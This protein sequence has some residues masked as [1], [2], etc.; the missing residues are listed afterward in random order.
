MKN[1]LLI[2][3]TGN[4]KGKTTAALGQ[5][6]RALG[7]D[8]R[9]CMIQ[10]IKGSWEYGEL[11]S[12]KRFEDLLDFHVMGKG[13][14]FKS[15]DI[16]VDK[17]LA[18]KGWELAKTALRSDKYHLLVL[19][20][21]TYLLQYHFIE[22]TEVIDALTSRRDGLNVVVT[23][24][25]AP[26]ELIDIANLVTYMQEIKHPYKSGIKARKGVEF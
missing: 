19:D 23:G 25:N 10:F 18:R 7:H 1:G 15:E 16:E 22:L 14:T 3:N 5:T 11:N 6:L 26:Q 8:H 12:V 13:F 17:K 2:V 20:E 21:L 24:R 9:V 4:G